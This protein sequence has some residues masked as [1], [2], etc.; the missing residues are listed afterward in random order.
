MNCK[1]CNKNIFPFPVYQ[2]NFCDK[3]CYDKY[4]QKLEQNICSICKKEQS[5]IICDNNCGYKV[6]KN[7]NFCKHNCYE[8][9]NTN[10]LCI[11][12]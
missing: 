10:F 1:F 2:N 5:I 8:K 11:I 3:N 7:C 4:E 9:N 12:S 6:C